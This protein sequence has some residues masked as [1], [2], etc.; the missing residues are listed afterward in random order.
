MSVFF[1][2]RAGCL[3][4][5]LLVSWSFIIGSPAAAQSVPRLRVAGA[6]QPVR[7]QSLAI[8]TEIRGG[9]AE[10]SLEMVFYNPNGRILEGVLEF[11]LAPGQ[12]ISGLALDINGE[13]RRGVPVPKARGQEVFDDI[14]RRRVDPALLEATGGNAYRLRVYPLPSHGVRRV[15]V[16]VMQPL[17]AE[18]GTLRYRL[19]LA[20]AETLDSFSFEA[21]I[22][23]P[24]GPVRAEAGKLALSLEREG[25][26]YRGRVERQNFIPEGWLDISLPAPDSLAASATGARWRD[27]LYF[28]AAAYTPL[29]DKARALPD[30]VTIVW[31]ASLSGLERNHADEFALLDRYFKA[32]GTGQARLIV[33][34]D[35][36]GPPQTF[37]IKNGGWQSLRA[38]LE[39]V[40][41]DGAT[42]LSGWA[43]TAD[44]REYLF[45][46]DGMGNYGPA[47]PLRLAA[48][49]RLF[50]IN[51]AAVA[52][53]AALRALA[54]RGQVIDLARE[55]FQTAETRLLRESA[56]VSLVPPAKVGA[57][58][59]VLAPE[60]AALSA[61]DGQ[62]GL[63]R[64]AGWAARGG[65]ENVAVRV[66]FPDGTAK[67]LTIPL[68]AWDESPEF[69]GEEAPLPAR[70]W[71]RYAIA[72]LEADY[73]AN[74]A[75]IAALGQELGLVT[76]TTSLI[77]LE[78]ARDYA[79]YGVTP[80]AS[81]QAKVEALNVG[82]VATAGERILDEEH[83]SSLW[84][85]KLRWWKIDFSLNPKAMW[86]EGEKIY[87][88]QK[89]SLDYQNADLHKII[90]EIAEV[91]GKRIVISDAVRGRVTLRLRD[92][93]WDQALD[94]ILSSR[95]LSVE[96]NGKVL[97]V[98]D[99][100]M[101]ERRVSRENMRWRSMEA[102][103]A[104]RDEQVTESTPSSLAVGRMTKAEALLSQAAVTAAETN[105]EA[106]TISAPRVMAA[107]GQEVS[108]KQ[109]QQIPYTSGSSATTA[110]NVNF[111]SFSSR[112]SRSAD[113]SSQSDVGITASGPASKAETAALYGKP[114]VPDAAYIASMRAA[115]DE[116][117]YAVYLDDRRYYRHSSAFFCDVA[118]IF[119]ERGSR[120]L[121]LRVLS[122]LAE[123]QLEDR[124]ILRGLAYRLMAQDEMAAALPILEQVR[125]LA[126]YEPQSLRD[127]VTVKAALGQVQEAAELLYKV[128]HRQWSSRFRDINTI[129]L[130]EMNALIAAH[131]DRIDTKAIDL[132]LSQNL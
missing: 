35:K 102:A 131:E 100:P 128:A 109:G 42:N 74:Q 10:S 1:R 54:V 29:P 27:K 41:Y 75:A 132:Q 15:A 25:T 57:A 99:L 98:Y 90:R 48:E 81:L 112:R 37:D 80:P 12:E 85:R 77:V 116:K 119:F 120:E 83:L 61:A 104:P 36:A 14:T 8:R 16:R 97:T 79:Q 87:T 113:S 67:T 96:E 59:A 78:T 52:D 108:L 4:A 63:I 2:F 129:T 51:S 130:T 114:W 125:E 123:M 11:P 86:Y 88:G 93:P 68:P 24:E 50:A 91:S 111:P 53:Y 103:R 82:K 56:A 62:R 89:I 19:P 5:A 117:L 115:T 127:I 40:A 122:N 31:D 9:F 71:G 26:L 22:V 38:A 46:S 18:S 58:E 64:V 23:S 94:I 28:N 7:L 30:V 20:F 110:A 33:L 69:T 44:C 43:P 107:D 47:G 49:Q 65:A 92:V 60:S 55:P 34:R 95:G 32:F 70:L 84:G 3:L 105:D 13:M 124:R 121:G 72:A 6:E 45:I 39:S 126:P 17:T 106:K 101:L 21:E 76:R 73:R 118:D 66:A